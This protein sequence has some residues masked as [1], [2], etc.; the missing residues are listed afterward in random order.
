MSITTWC[1]C[2][3][4]QPGMTVAHVAACCADTQWASEPY[5]AEVLYRE[6]GPGNGTVI[7]SVDEYVAFV[8]AKEAVARVTAV[9][10]EVDHVAEDPRFGSGLHH[11]HTDMIWR[12][13]GNTRE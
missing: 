7:M 6:P 13:L 12:A 8:A 2:A 11:V 5:P 10:E 9:L 1:R 4:H 3:C